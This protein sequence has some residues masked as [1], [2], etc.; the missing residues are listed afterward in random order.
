[1]TPATWGVS[2]CRVHLQAAG[3]D[4]PCRHHHRDGAGWRT[5]GRLSRGAF[6]APPACPRCGVPAPL[7]PA[8]APST[9]PRLRNRFRSVGALTLA[10]LPRAN[11][12]APL[13]CGRGRGVGV[14][15]ESTCSSLKA[16]H[17]FA[18]GRARSRRRRRWPRWCAQP[19]TPRSPSIRRT[20]T[21]VE[22]I[23]YLEIFHPNDC[24]GSH[25]L[26]K[27]GAGVLSSV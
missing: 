8:P 21:E 27:R 13:G 10:A 2:R 12:R 3:D 4:C 23:P 9:R 16:W 1:M 7:D 22:H 14:T 17:S 5:A 26:K 24:T 11:S 6:C 20:R 25:L 18:C 19:T 15:Q